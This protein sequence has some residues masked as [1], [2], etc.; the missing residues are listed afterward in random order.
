M[1]RS[2]KHGRLG[3]KIIRQEVEM[4]KKLRA[5]IRLKI[6]RNA[7]LEFFNLNSYL[8]NEGTDMDRMQDES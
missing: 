7:T 3:V 4:K 5:F 1:I 2:N 8:A 6:S